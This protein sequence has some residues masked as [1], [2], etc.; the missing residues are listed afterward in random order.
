[1]SIGRA[2]SLPLGRRVAYWRAR[3]G[4]SQQV[5]ADRLGKSKSWADKVERGVRR[6]DRYSVLNDIADVLHVDVYLLLGRAPSRRDNGTTGIDQKTVEQVRAALTR[7]EG[8]GR[9][10][11]G[12]PGPGQL[13]RAVTHAWLSL[14][15]ADYD[16]LLQS[17]PTLIGRGQWLRADHRDQQTAELLGQVYQITAEL[18][19]RIGEHHL[20]WLAAD[21]A[22]IVSAD[23]ADPL[24]TGR[25]VATLAEVVRAAGRPRHAVELAATM[26]HRLSHPAPMVD[27]ARRLSVVGALLLQA[28]LGAAA[29]TDA[30]ATTSLIDQA[31]R[32]ANQ[33]G[34]GR[35]HHH[36]CFG[37]ALVAIT[38]AVAAVELGHGPQALTGLDDLARLP[39]YQRL[40]TAV[41]ANHL[42]HVARAH[43]QAGNPAAAGHALLAAARTA[44][45]E[46]RT[47]P[48]A[49]ATLAA[50]LRRLDQPGPVAHL[51]ETIGVTV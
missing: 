50:V 21:R 27:E 2:E 6:L 12:I 25:A 43:L 5:F 40:P 22:V 42:I 26:A 33:V 30:A 19:R 23:S 11:P 45:A 9:R 51:A 8:L 18:L 28:A 49:R 38:R 24:H 7:H 17:L 10:P 35:D 32:A 13:D 36:T 14:D 48:L 46:V 34:H 4:M 31:A 20:A 29:S 16:R 41:R 3:R 37:P 39:D 1:M 15:R 44:P 47:R